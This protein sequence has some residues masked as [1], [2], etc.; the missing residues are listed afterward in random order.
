MI[1]PPPLPLKR[2]LCL[3]KEKYIIKAMSLLRQRKGVWQYVLHAQRKIIRH[4]GLEK[5]LNSV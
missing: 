4:C 5:R 2:M 3:T 1:E